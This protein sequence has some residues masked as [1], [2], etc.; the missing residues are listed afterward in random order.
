MYARAQ[1]LCEITDHHIMCCFPRAACLICCNTMLACDTQQA[2]HQPRHTH[3]HT[4][5]HRHTCTHTHIRTQ[6]HTYTHTHSCKQ[7]HTH[8]HACTL[9]STH[10][11]TGTQAQDTCTSTSACLCTGTHTCKECMHEVLELLAFTQDNCTENSQ[12]LLHSLARV[13]HG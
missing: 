3:I 9:T 13:Q 5:T 6:T 4:H 1:C 12:N 10:M 2:E 8:T 11:H 7:A